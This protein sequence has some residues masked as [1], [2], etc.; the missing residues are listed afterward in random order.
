MVNDEFPTPESI[1]GETLYQYVKQ[2]LVQGTLSIN[3]LQSLNRDNATFRVSCERIG[4]PHQ[5]RA[6]DVD[7]I[8]LDDA[9]KELEG[10]DRRQAT[11]VEM[12]FF[13]GLSMPEIAAALSIGQTTA[14]DAW[15]MARA[16][17]RRR[18]G[19]KEG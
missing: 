9:L 3:T 10:L 14:E 6:P 7:V 2:R 8:A 4:G 16:W 19:A 11:V 17:L 5:F 18:L 15:Y 1:D 12:R 13:G